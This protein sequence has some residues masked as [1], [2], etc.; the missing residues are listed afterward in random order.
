M[1][2][3]LALALLAAGCF[4]ANPTD[5]KLKCFSDPARAC[6][7]NY[8]CASD[9][10]C[11]RDG[12]DPDLGVSDDAAVGTRQ[13]GDTCSAAE[14]CAAGLTCVDSICCNNACGDAC[15][16]CNVPGLLGTCSPVP[17]GSMP[18]HSTCNAESQASCGRDGACD[19]SGKCRNWFNVVCKTGSCTAGMGIGDSRCDGKGA[20]VAPAAIA[21]DPYKCNSAGTACL[22]SCTVDGDCVMPNPC[23]LTVTPGSCGPKNNGLP[24][25]KTADCKTGNC[26]DTVCCDTAAGMCNGCRACNLPLNEGKC[27]NVPMGQDP[28][29]ACTGVVCA[30]GG[31]NSTGTCTVAPNTT[32]CQVTTCANNDL[33]LGQYGSTTANTK[34]CDGVTTG[35]CGGS[36]SVAPCS[37]R[38]TCASSIACR[39]SCVAHSDCIRVAFCNAG[40]CDF[41]AINGMPCTSDAG[42]V[43]RVCV[44][45]VCRACRTSRD[46]MAAGNGPICS[47]N[48][49]G[50]CQN[51]PECSAAGW[52]SVCDKTTIPPFGYCACQNS[53]ECSNGT[54][55][56]CSSG[57][58]P[59]CTCNGITCGIGQVCVAGTCKNGQGFP[60]VVG[61]DCA[62]SACNSG[63]CG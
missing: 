8:H 48:A 47:A 40:A 46:C 33:A 24:C 19:G 39:Q 18:A 7:A 27:T 10:T 23:N 44:G 53:G 36:A 2:K 4:T 37:G 51:G 57:T 1:N 55:N 59:T 54:S 32:A 56:T 38:F 22:G 30:A 20:C 28:H 3:L 43:S 42:C 21:C 6:P 26:V 29:S 50:D 52:G 41:R 31:C 49:C 16:A 5:G 62:S 9:N 25:T 12:N 14:G 45:N 17:A 13:K 58:V 60:C 34:F 61:G 63:V 15:M 35:V 11:W